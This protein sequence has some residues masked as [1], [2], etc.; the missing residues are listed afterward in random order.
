MNDDFLRVGTGI[1]GL[2]DMVEGGLPFP[3][4]HLLAGSPGSGKTT[5]CLQFLFEGAK[6]GEKGLYLTTLSE[7]TNWMIRF[8]SRFSFVD[9]NAIGKDIAYFDLGPYFKSKYPP[10]D[11]YETLKR[12]IEDKI[13]E[14][15]PQRIVIDPITSVE[16]ILK[17]SY[18]EFLFDLSQSLKNWQ[19]VTLMTGETTPTNPY[20][21]EPAYTTD[22][23][24]ILYHLEHPD[25]RRRYIEVL[26]MRGTDH[27]TGKHMVDISED[28]LS[29][30][31][32][33]K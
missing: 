2:D 25:G 32:G 31:V 22:G 16:N 29:V 11:R 26:K 6:R 23:I 21:M 28:G 3:S 13:V 1:P 27:M 8:T 20:P 24:I 12:V 9:K 33:F 17:D 19:A 14:Q 18:R 5:F 10:E 7:P 4:T 15:M 30:Q